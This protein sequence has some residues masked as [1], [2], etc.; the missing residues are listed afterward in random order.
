MFTSA[1]G[2]NSGL[3][4]QGLSRHFRLLVTY[5]QVSGK[6][7]SADNVKFRQPLVWIQRT[8]CEQVFES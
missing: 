1:P 4:P 7:Q 3:F 5:W 2:A 6:R 8:F